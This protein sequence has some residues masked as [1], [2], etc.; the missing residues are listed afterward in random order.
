MFAYFCNV[1]IS[2]F[3]SI[4][5]LDTEHNESLFIFQHVTYSTFIHLYV[6]WIAQPLLH[7]HVN[8]PANCNDK[9][10]IIHSPGTLIGT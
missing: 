10:G 7:E 5:G 1:F 2:D 8:W 6:G 4:H 3:Y 9:I